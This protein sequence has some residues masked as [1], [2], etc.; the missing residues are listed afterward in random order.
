MKIFDLKE[1]AGISNIL[2]RPEKF[3]I[4]Q[5]GSFGRFNF[6]L[7]KKNSLQISISFQP[8]FTF[9]TSIIET[10]I[11]EFRLNLPHPGACTIKLLQ[12]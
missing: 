6:W 7:E 2:L 11:F 8:Q 3:L 12:Q 5:K 4:E 1:L 9:N 10:V